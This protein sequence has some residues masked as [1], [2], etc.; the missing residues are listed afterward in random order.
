MA[1]GEFRGPERRVVVGRDERC[2]REKGKSGEKRGG[3][4]AKWVNN[5][6]QQGRQGLA[7]TG[8]LGPRPGPG[9]CAKYPN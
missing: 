5:C 1:V 2:K 9:S 7:G 4:D 3:R 6:V 8:V